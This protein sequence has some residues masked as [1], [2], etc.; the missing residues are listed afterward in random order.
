M[1]GMDIVGAGE[2]GE[3]EGGAGAADGMP[4]VQRLGATRCGISHCIARALQLLTTLHYSYFYASAGGEDEAALEALDE[5]GDAEED[6]EGDYDL[7][8]GGEKD[9][10]GDDGDD[11]GGR[12]AEY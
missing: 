7:W 2:D 11:G 6:E 5:E 9:D 10:D 8:D 4:I 3:G 1:P 12:E